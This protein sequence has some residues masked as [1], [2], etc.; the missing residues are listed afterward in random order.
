MN[1]IPIRYDGYLHLDVQIED[2]IN[3]NFIFDTG[4]PVLV[5]DSLFCKENRLDF[6][7]KD[8]KI[9]G[10]GNE[11][12]IA[13]LITDTIHYK[14]SDKESFFSNL[15]LILNLKNMVGKKINGIAGIQTFAQKPYMIDYVSQN[16]IFTDSVKGY[17]ALNAQ[18]KNN[19]IYI[20]L[21]VKLN[22]GKVIEGKF[23]LD[24]GSNQTILNSHIF[25][26]D[27]IFN[28]TEKK[29][30][31][32]KGGVGGDSNG[33]FLP[34]AAINTGKF[35]IK[36]FITTISTDTLGSLADSDHMG[37]IGNDLLDNFDIIFDHQK[38]KIWVKPNKN[39]NKNKRK[40]FR[41]ISFQDTGEK[42]IVAG[43][44]EETE[45]FRQGIRMNDQIIQVNNVPVEKIDLDKFVEEL[46][47]NDVLLL[48]IKRG[49]EEKE[50]KIKLTVFLES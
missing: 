33:Y 11:T 3:S 50:I 12:K 41:C 17:E 47:A 32:S 20:T 10:I 36:N 8:I 39:F 21:S 44:V 29:K 13:Q 34:V 28:A 4:A 24:T 37:T 6:L 35:K 16:I 45:A 19:N 7:T 23:L 31:Y 15:S 48:R 46:K 14:V 42:W 5:L 49:N 22:N 2:K 1:S 43:I 27:G 9:N 30:F 40:L 38:E 25:M 18:F 26:T